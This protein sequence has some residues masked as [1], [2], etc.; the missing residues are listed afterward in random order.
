MLSTFFGI[1]IANRAI[2]TAT[3]DIDVTGQNVANSATTGY[4]EEVAVNTA[5]APYTVPM[6]NNPDPGQVGTG[7]EVSQISRQ[8]DPWVNSQVNAS[9]SNLSY[10]ETLTNQL[11]VAQTAFQEPTTIGLQS[12]MDTFF[13]DWQTLSTDPTNMGSRASVVSDATQLIDDFHTSS[14]LLSQNAADIQSQMNA[15]VN[16]STTGG[17]STINQMAQQIA[18]LNQQIAS[19]S[20]QGEQPNDLEDSR[21]QLVTQLSQLV[22]TSVTPD[23]SNDGAVSVSIYGDTLVSSTASVANTVSLTLAG[24]IVASSTVP[25]SY[26]T[27][28]GTTTPVYLSG[29]SMSSSYANSGGLTALEGAYQKTEDYIGQL[30]TLAYNLVQDVNMQHQEGANSQALISSASTTIASGSFDLQVGTTITAISFSNTLGTNQG[31]LAG[32]ASA[33]NTDTADGATATVVNDPQTGTSYLNVVSSSGT[34]Q[35]VT[36]SDIGAGTVIGYTGGSSGYTSQSLSSSGTPAFTYGSGQFTISVGTSPPVTI[37]YSNATTNLS[38]LQ[39]MASAINADSADG[40]TATVLSDT[41][42][43][44]S[45]LNVV[46]SSGTSQPVTLGDVGTGT[47]I[48]YAGR[49]SGY[50]STYDY[51]GDPGG[52]FFNPLSTTV[53]SATNISLSSNISPNADGSNP[54]LDNI[55]AASTTSDQRDGNNALAMNN[56]QNATWNSLNSGTFDSYYATT[57]EAVGADVQNATQ[58]QSTAQTTNTQLTNMQQSVSGVSTDEEMT[59]LVQFQYAYQAA[60]QFLSVQNNLLNTLVNDTLTAS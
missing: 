9:D 33:I 18:A 39:N 13:N 10:W 47:V 12:A 52:L 50:T 28:A 54:N 5:T 26:L 22:P 51:N 27:I 38:L 58:M 6:L 2:Q 17:L 29:T 25:N 45:Y 56:L 60:A 16:N 34:P 8:T 44:T 42:N 19:V 55:A 53:G 46:S 4:T 36:L 37:S 15:D 49:S 23:P 24:S 57:T 41:Q 7:V 1:E 21:D 30:D 14:G 48:Q 3:Q 31:L 43:G 11:Q 32:M 59:K 20:A 40:A 35:A